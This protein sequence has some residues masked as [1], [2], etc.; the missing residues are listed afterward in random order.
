MFRA[1]L[2]LSCWLAGH[3]LQALAQNSP[4]TLDS[5]LARAAADVNDPVAHYDVAMAF[6]EK[7]RWD[8]AERELHTALVIAPSY[9]EAYLALAALPKAKGD[10]YW[11]KRVKAEGEEAVHTIFVQ[12]DAHYRHAFLLNPLVD[13]G[14]LGKFESEDRVRFVA[15][16]KYL[17]ALIPPWWGNEMEKGVN[18]FRGGHY[19]RAFDRFQ[20]LIADHRIGSDEDAP[21]PIL[22]YHG[23][24][25]GHLAN[26]DA[27]VRDFAV[28]TGRGVAREKARAEPDATLPLRTNDYRYVLATMLYLAGRFNEAIPTFK[29]TLE[30][31]FGLYVS[32]VQLARIYAAAQLWD[33]AIRERQAAV[34]ANVDDSSLYVELGATLMQAGHA[35]DA[36][37][38]LRR[39]AGMNP[40]DARTPYILGF[41]MTQLARPDDARVA[42]ERFL[43]IAPSPYHT[44]IEEVRTRLAELH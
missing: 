30:I 16:G 9:A 36:E 20:K 28:L 29:R 18:D 33:D 1:A 42:F 14:V 17:I 5:L 23:L 10:K 32:H 6:W 11:K 13:L 37:E 26:F 41:V 43:A 3:T 15:Q 44:Q 22:W 19:D 4:P 35:A 21:D 34:E 39:A 7:K 31:D 2:L 8:D 24:A 12:S 25:A 38:P 40:R 27:A